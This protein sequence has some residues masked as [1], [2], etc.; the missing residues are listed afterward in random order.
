MTLRI[1]DHWLECDPEDGIEIRREHARRG[2]PLVPKLVIGHY[3]VTH[4]LDALV[5][6]QKAQGFWAH[7]SID[8]WFTGTHSVIQIVQAL[9]FNETG[10]H[11]GESRWGDLVGLNAHS[12]GIEISNPGPLVRGADGLLR[13]TYGRVWPEEEAVEARHKHPGAPRN[14]THWARYTKEEV[15]L[16]AALYLLL[17]ETYPIQEFVG[18]D[19]VSPGRKFDPG[20]A[21]ALARAFA[22]TAY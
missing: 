9:P 5:A 12:I 20:P 15:D 7:L 14:W 13:T 6:A 10:S 22:P 17:R 19:D 21:F 1:V 8:G 16:C 18:H 2:K 4:S 3:G 11:A